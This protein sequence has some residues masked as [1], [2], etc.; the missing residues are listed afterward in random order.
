M[1]KNFLLLAALLFSLVIQAQPTQVDWEVIASRS[2]GFGD[3]SNPVS[4][5][6]IWGDYNN[7]GHKDVFLIGGQWDET[8]Q[9][10][11]N[12]GDGTFTKEQDDAFQKMARA[13]AVFIDYDNDGDLDLIATGVISSN[14]QV[15]VYENTGSA[16]AYA[17]VKSEERSKELEERANL[18]VGH[19]YSKDGNAV[20]R[21][22]QVADY[23]NDGWMDLIVSGNTHYNMYGWDYHANDGA[24]TWT[25]LWC[26]TGIIKNNGGTFKEQFDLIV[27][28]GRRSNFIYVRDGSIHVGDINGDGYIDIVSQGFSDYGQDY[29]A[30][31]YTNNQNGTFSTSSFS[32]QLGTIEGSET[33][34]V[35]INSDGKDDIVEI[36]R[37]YANIY[38]N[39][40]NGNF[41]KHE[42]NG[43]ITTNGATITAGDIN[44][45]GWVDL[46]VSGMDNNGAALTNG[47]KVF[48]N[49][50]DLTF[51]PAE[52]PENMRARTGNIGLVDIDNDGNMDYSNFGWNDGPTVAI[53]INKLGEGISANAAPGIPS[54]LSV[55]YQ[56]GKIVM[57]WSAPADDIT[58]AAALRYNVYAKDKNT[59][60]IYTYAPVDITTGRLKI[61]GE[62]VPL[63]HGTSYKMTLPVGEYTIGVQ[64]VDQADATSTFATTDFSITELQQIWTAI[65]T[66][67]NWDLFMTAGGSCIWGDYNNDGYLDAF[68]NAGNDRVRLYE[69]HAGIFTPTQDGAFEGLKEG[70]S[71]FIDYNND[72]FLDLITTGKADADGDKIK[73]AVYKNKGSEANY[74]YELDAEAS[75]QLRGI[76]SGDGDRVG[77]MLNAVD[78]N[79][80]GWVDLVISGN[81]SGEHPMGLSSGRFTAVYKNIGGS[82]EL[83]QNNVDGGNFSQMAGGAVHVGDFNNDGYPDIV[84]IGYSD[85]DGWTSALYKN[86]GDE[87]FSKVAY[88]GLDDN[89][90]C[91]IVFADMNNDGYDDIIEITSN[92]ANIHI[93]NGDGTFTVL[94]ASTTG[95]IKSQAANIA[96]G[97]VNNDGFNDIF[98]SGYDIP[99]FT[100]VF[101]NNGDNTFTYQEIVPGA[102]PGTAN[103][104]DMTNDMNLDL[105]YY[106]WGADAGWPN[107]FFR[108]DLGKGIVSNTA[109]TTPADLTITYA[110]GKIQMSWTEATDAETPTSAIRY[111]IYVKNEATGAIYA[112]AP[113]D[114]ATGKLRI[115][116]GIIPLIS[117]T[118][119][120][121]ALPAGEYTIGVQAVDQANV[122]SAFITEEYT[123]AS[124]IEVVALSPENGADGVLIDAAVTVTFN[125]PVTGSFAGI[126]IN[127]TAAE[128]TVSESVMTIAHSNFTKGT[129]YTIV[130]PA[131]AIDGYT[132]AITWSF[133]TEMSSGLNDI[134][135]AGSIYVSGQTLYT[136][137]YPATASITI[138]NVLGQVVKDIESTTKGIRL[139]SGSYIVKIQSE[140]KTETHKVLVK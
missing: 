16:N 73:I 102:R 131:G 140:G 27:D 112:Y 79:N 106:G 92:V 133:R 45:D 125:A 69:N 68:I 86:N 44:N 117:K 66:E 61:G 10:W 80:D 83:Q 87:T 90:K 115:G 21:I 127:G 46:M 3:G 105:S 41:T 56:N 60:T 72:G 17:F 30:R 101:Y 119:F 8:V 48:Y 2:N 75:A 50:G 78:Y 54:D 15:Y 118:S 40:G 57:K 121:M 85:S 59:G 49:N 47:I 107:R 71:I 64:A 81:I 6:L 26:Y 99:N 88:D 126:T 7:D 96:V 34:F 18:N 24:G 97:D 22:F 13:S 53:A 9:L 94:D 129:N 132:E 104:V 52:L 23:D 128:S 25:Y 42:S 28:G 93:S 116:G 136:A 12:N 98:T 84:N 95:L 51:T 14:N 43:L 33:L 35:D 67:E 110:D 39:E 91:D 139:S 134:T 1:K 114:I 111:N 4:G 123:V 89:E 108:N 58:P 130:I 37:N 137:G 31:L 63:I 124:T 113:A 11:K 82:F 36:S 38:V 138:Y 76:V 74:A 122:A 29:K 55:A 100:A 120:E 70:Y 32:S 135:A 77:H 5:R 19:D 65:K 103:L 20:G 62:I 109:P